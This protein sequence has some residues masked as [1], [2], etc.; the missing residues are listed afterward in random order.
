MKHQ[1]RHRCTDADVGVGMSKHTERYE[2]T[3]D[4]RVFS[5]TGWRGHEM[6]ELA[7]TLNSSGYLSVRVTANGRR[8]RK[9][10]HGLVARTHIGPPPAPGYEVRHL[11]GNKSNNN[12]RNLAW[13]TKKE[14]ADDRERHGRTSRGEK[15]SKAIKA[16]NHAEAVRAFRRAQKEGANV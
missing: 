3:S 14:N 9:T 2:V 13:G 8:V 6:R 7:Q 4:G 10:V 15:H 1:I 11:D 16:S 12:F 5:Y